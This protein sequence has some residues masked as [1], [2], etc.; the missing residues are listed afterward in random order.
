MFGAIKAQ[1]NQITAKCA[2]T[3]QR[4]DAFASRRNG[5]LLW[6]L[7]IFYKLMLDAMYIW[8]ASPQYGYAGLIYMPM[9]YKYAAGM[10]M[11]FLIFASLPKDENSVASVLLHIQFMYTVAP[12]LTFYS[13]ANGS[14]KYMLMVFICLILESL[15][16]RY[17]SKNRTP[18]YIKGVKNYV[19][20]LM[21]I[22]IFVTITIPILYNGF[23]GAKAFDFEYIYEMRA[24]ATYPPGF[25]YLFFWMGKAIIPFFAVY[26]LDK[27]KYLG[28]I[29]AIA[30]QILLYIECGNKY[31]L[32]ILVPV[33][34]I[35]YCAKTKHL[36]KL[37]YLGLSILFFAMIPAY[38][39]DTA[40]GNAL[41]VR[42]SFYVSV[43]AIF[44]PADN[45]FAMFECF[46]QF[47]KLYFS[48]GLI[49]KML[50]LTNL[51]NG[52]EGQVVFAYNGGDFKSA[53]LNTGYLGESYAQMGF[54]GMLLMS[55]LFAFVL[56][57]IESYNS[58][59]RFCV[60][61]A[62]FAMFIINLNDISLLTTLLSS[63]MAIVILLVAA[64]FEKEPGDLRN[65]I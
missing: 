16:V 33:I 26:L 3:L 35:Y 21:W 48:Q 31:L 41:G 53:N 6:L 46:S 13:M 52:S 7:A 19:T 50:G 64:Y 38:L 36:I 4:F 18:V 34:F 30:L 14:N 2:D 1:Y 5:V 49:G 51:Y 47:P 17:G 37:A 43:R 63:G 24:K 28:A 61:T 15:I 58:R 9:F 57:A 39:F 59:K 62:V 40:S 56:R 55:V 60:L 44:H 45:K 27:K 42:S 11:Y 65:G 23:A 29:A 25:A 12:L 22:L 10:A 20:V 32:F 54:V 8:V